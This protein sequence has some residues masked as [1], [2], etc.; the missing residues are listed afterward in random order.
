MGLN[1]M[2]VLVSARQR[3]QDVIITETHPKVLYWQIA[4]ARYDYANCREEMDGALASRL[5]IVVAPQT[6]HEWDA[7]ISAL[8]ALQSSEGRWPHDL[9]RTATAAN[10]RL[11]EPCGKTRYS[12]PE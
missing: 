2:A 1:G 10:E 8:A 5:G 7:A 12:W 4:R 6:E 9:H 11:I 3:F